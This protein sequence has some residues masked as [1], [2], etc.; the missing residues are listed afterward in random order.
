LAGSIESVD[1]GRNVTSIEVS[2][3]EH[4]VGPHN[5]IKREVLEVQ[6]VLGEGNGFGARTEFEAQFG[7]EQLK[8]SVVLIL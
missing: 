4:E 6:A 7:M 3:R 8:L 1:A 2:N 5:L